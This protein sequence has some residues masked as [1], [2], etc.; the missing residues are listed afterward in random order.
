[1][2]RFKLPSEISED[3]WPAP[4]VFIE[5]AKDLVKSARE[6]KL[7]I[8]VMGGLAIYLHSLEHEALW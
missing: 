4:S 6:Q 7:E 1:M 2:D 8:R 5:E 3:E